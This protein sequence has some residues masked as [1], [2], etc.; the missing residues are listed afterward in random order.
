MLSVPLVAVDLTVAV[1]KGR[2][3]PVCAYL[4]GTLP[5]GEATACTDNQRRP[6]PAMLAL[7]RAPRWASRTRHS[8]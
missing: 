3:R 4:A 1:V 7:P 2:I 6:W 8:L 5:A